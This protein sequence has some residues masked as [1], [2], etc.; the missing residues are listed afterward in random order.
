MGVQVTNGFK[1]YGG[2][3]LVLNDLNLNVG[4]G[5]MYGY[6]KTCSLWVC[7]II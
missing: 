1:R 6:Y 3:A 5:E 4:R 2:G 7:R